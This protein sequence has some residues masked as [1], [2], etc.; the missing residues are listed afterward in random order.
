MDSEIARTTHG[1]G[2]LYAEDL[3]RVVGESII[4]TTILYITYHDVHV[5][6][7]ILCGSLVYYT[8]DSLR[9]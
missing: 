5:Y 6:Y 1:Q 8:P 7:Y 4:D 2:G 3:L 9:K